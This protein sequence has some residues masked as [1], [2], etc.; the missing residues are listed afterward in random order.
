ML[1]GNIMRN[2]LQINDMIDMLDDFVANQSARQIVVGGMA[3]TS[4]FKMVMD[5]ILLNHEF[6][7]ICIIEGCQDYM[8][9]T[10]PMSNHMYYMDTVYEETIIEEDVSHD[11]YL[12]WGLSWPDNRQ[13]S[14][15]RV[16]LC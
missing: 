8:G 4:V 9:L 3:G 5:S 16:L 15:F 6:K 13:S 7:E 2:I 11:Y 10:D 1:K 14:I 12:T